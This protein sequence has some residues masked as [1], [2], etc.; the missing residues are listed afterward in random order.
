MNEGYQN[1]KN[2][3]IK[4]FMNGLIDYAGLFPPARLPLDQAINNFLNYQQCDDSWMLGTFIIPAESL[5]DLEQLVTKLQSHKQLQL[6]VTGGKSES[7]DNCLASFEA[8]LQKIAHFR[9]MHGQKVKI[10][11]F[12][13][14][15]PL[16]V[17]QLEELRILAELAKTEKVKL[18]TEVTMSESEDWEAQ[19][20]R[21]LDVFEAQNTTDENPIGV[22]LRT[23]GLEAKMFPSPVKTAVFIKGCAERKLPLKFTAGLHHP[24]RMYR[25]EV[26]TK[27]HGF[28]NVFTAGIL[29]YARDFDKDL[30]AEILED[31]QPDHFKFRDTELLWKDFEVYAAEIANNRSLLFSYGSCSFDEPR[32]E[33]RKL[34]FL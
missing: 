32:D 3:S 31:E 24:I 5:K 26:Q 7:F 25:D 27:M 4:A 11:V 15:L 21:T 1:V 16:A 8:D 28:I 23:G 33:L 9:H 2:G 29:G 22:K 34:N 13:L 12:E 18:F 19:L 10:E 14:P 20:I 17:P 6:S 30:I